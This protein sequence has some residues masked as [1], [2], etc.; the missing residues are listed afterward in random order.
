MQMAQTPNTEYQQRKCQGKDQVPCLSLIFLLLIDIWVQ[1]N[2][3]ASLRKQQSKDIHKSQFTWTSERQE[4]MVRTVAHQK[5]HVLLKESSPFSVQLTDASGEWGSR[6]LGSSN[7]SKEVGHLAL[8]VK[9]PYFL[10]WNQNYLQCCW[11]YKI[12]PWLT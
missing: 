9:S 10:T 1:R 8:Y 4:G 3:F 7:I 12:R 11:P 2:I 6:I 5:P